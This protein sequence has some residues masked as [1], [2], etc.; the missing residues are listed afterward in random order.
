MRKFT[1]IVLFAALANPAFAETLVANQG[2]DSVRLT[3]KPCTNP[4]VLVHIAIAQQE[5][6]KA[7]SAVFQ[8]Q[9][10]S[11]CW[12]VMGDVAHLLYEDGD[13]G[14]VSM[15]LLKPALEL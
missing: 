15:G 5:A 9:N 13:Q 12:R 7:G 8:G 11:A 10:Y 2:S 4:L 3:D 1:L 14:V 6:Y